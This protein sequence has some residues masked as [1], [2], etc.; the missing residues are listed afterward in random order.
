MGRSPVLATDSSMLARSAFNVISPSSVRI[1]PGIIRAPEANGL[2]NGDEL[3]SVREGRLD[4]DLLDHLGHAVHDLLASQDFRAGLHQ[5]RH[6]VA[7]ASPFDNRVSNQCNS[8][9]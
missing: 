3:G 4:L 8:L 9:G 7:V 5:V 1:S 2:M 6:R